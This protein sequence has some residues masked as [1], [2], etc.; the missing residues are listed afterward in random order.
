MVN[1]VLSKLGLIKKHFKTTSVLFLVLHRFENMFV[2]D[3]FSIFLPLIVPSVTVDV[4]VLDF[5]SILWTL[6]TRH[7][8]VDSR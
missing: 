2:V 8:S 3:K 6:I 4:N 7:V 1:P 5:R